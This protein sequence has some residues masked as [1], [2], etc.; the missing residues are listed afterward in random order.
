MEGVTINSYDE[1]GNLKITLNDGES[2]AA[3]GYNIFSPTLDDVQGY[4]PKKQMFKNT[5][6]AGEIN[7]FD[8][9]VTVEKKL[10]GG[11]YWIITSTGSDV[12][13]DD[14][15]EFS[16][17]DKDDVLGLFSTYGLSTSTGDVLELTKFIIT[18]YAKKGFNGYEFHSKLYEGIKGTNGVIAGLYFRAYYHSYG[19]VDLNFKWRVYYYE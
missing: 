10:C 16:I 19:T 11:E 18:D 12:H 15:V 1:N 6:T 5:I 3:G 17:I 14:Y 2:K 8:E 13:D 9:V 7:I 4:Y